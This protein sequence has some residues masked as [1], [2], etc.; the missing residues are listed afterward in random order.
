MD[1]QQF[2][3][4]TQQFGATLSR[5]RVGGLLAALGFGAVGNTAAKP[6]KKK[7]KKK[8]KPCAAGAIRCGTACVNPQTDAGNCGGCGNLCPGGQACAGGACQG[9]SGCPSGQ[10][11]CGGACVDTQSNEQHCG[12]CG[13]ACQGDLTCLSGTCGCAAGTKC[14]N[15]CVDTQTDETHCGSCGNACSGSQSCAGGQCQ[16][17]GGCSGGQVTC[18]GECVNTETDTRHCGGCDTPCSVGRCISGAC[19][20]CTNQDDCGGYSSY[21]DLVCR[22]GRCGCADETKG[23]CQRF[24]DRSGSC[25]VCCPGGSGQCRFDEVCYYNQLPSGQRYGL[26]DCPAGWQRCNYQPHPTGTCV[27]DPMTDS[28]KCGR[29]CDDCTANTEF[30]AICCN[31]ACF[32]GC[33][34]P[35]TAFCPRGQICGPNCLPCNSDSI[36]CNMGP[37]TLPRCIPDIY[38]GTC[39]QN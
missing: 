25:H 26:C 34:G 28:R 2:D 24:S 15:Q 6:K 13:N 10:T 19:V 39:Y 3:R 14:G 32:R 17:G 9:G 21:N 1:S 4:L 22:N 27:Q 38:G 20:E 30:P 11:S 8:P 29:F 36:C 5:R 31:G 35:G 16:G 37:R 23:L 12:S 7:K 33:G 18:G